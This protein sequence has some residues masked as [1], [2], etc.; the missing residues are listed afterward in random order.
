M[1]RIAKQRGAF[2]VFFHLAAIIL[3]PPLG[4]A[5]AGP[6]AED[7]LEQNQYYLESLRLLEQA[8][9]RFNQGDYA[10]SE[11][12][13]QD[14]VKAAAQSDAYVTSQRKI[15][16]ANES[17]REAKERLAWADSIDAKTKY[18]QP[19]TEASSAYQD[20]EKAMNAKR[21]DAVAPPAN[22]AVAAV[23]EIEK[24]KSQEESAAK[25]EEERRKAEQAAAAVEQRKAQETANALAKAKARL[26]WANSINARSEYA[27]PYKRADTAYANA[28]KAQQSKQWDAAI[29]AANATVNAV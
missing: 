15:R 17:L 8:K 28:G 5:P 11:Q 24:L 18:P 26:D 16:S 25:A 20:A 14:A 3:L 21:Y 9:A 22:K 29:A 27:E 19:Y 12:Y 4:A 10:A 2:I 7:D 1:N 23:S 13:A 6:A